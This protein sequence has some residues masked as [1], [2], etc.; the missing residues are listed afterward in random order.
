MQPESL[1]E[2]MKKFLEFI[3]WPTV[4]GILFAV[5]LVQYQQ[6]DR[7]GEALSQLP[8]EDELAEEVPFSLAQAVD[9]AAP[10]IISIHSTIQMRS[11]SFP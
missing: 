2:F 1:R 10:S 7:L 11:Q 6:I 4:A 3:I 5:I 8:V 9:R